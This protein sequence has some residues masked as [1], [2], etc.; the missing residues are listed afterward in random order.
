MNETIIPVGQA[1]FENQVLQSALPVLVDYWAEW[2]APCK[3]MESVL[4]E[5][6]D[7]YRASCNLPR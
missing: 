3:A 7:E 4:H 5:L 1:N 6:A 2:C